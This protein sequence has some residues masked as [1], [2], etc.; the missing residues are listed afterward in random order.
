M[1]TLELTENEMEL[2]LAALALLQDV[3]DQN[4]HQDEA[5]AVR[6]LIEKIYTST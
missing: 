1:T 5:S 4:G 3:D 6:N 2:L